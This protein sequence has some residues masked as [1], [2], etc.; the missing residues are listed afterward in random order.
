[1]RRG[2]GARVRDTMGRGLEARVRIP[3]YSCPRPIVPI[4]SIGSNRFQYVP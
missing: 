1:M 2:I 3:M 4:G